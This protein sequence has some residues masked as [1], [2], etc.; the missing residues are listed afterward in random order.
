MVVNSP[1]A[2]ARRRTSSRRVARRR[3]RS[4]SRSSVGGG[5][6]SYKNKLVST[7]VGGFLYGVLEKSVGDKLPVIPI[8]GKSG[9]IA[10]GCYFF[11][12]NNSMIRDL[13]VA[14]AAI[15]GYSFGKTGSVSG[16]FDEE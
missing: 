5:G 11:G 10:V 6:G 4:R 12:K 9:T 13:G 14:A 8:L 3:T 15:A 7:G 2:P 16:D 1:A